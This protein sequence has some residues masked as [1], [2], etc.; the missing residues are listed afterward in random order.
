MPS[1]TENTFSCNVDTVFYHSKE[2]AKKY[3]GAIVNRL[4]SEKQLTIATARL[5]AEAITKGLCFTPA[6]L[7][8]T[9]EENFISQQSVVVDIDNEFKDIPIMTVD[10]AIRTLESNAINFA[11]IYHSFSHTPTLPKFRIVCV[12]SEPITDPEE[13][14]RLNQY[15]ISLFPQ[16]D[17]TCYN[18]DRFYYPTDK[19]LA[20]DVY[21]RTTVIKVPKDWQAKT[22]TKK[23]TKPPINTNDRKTTIKVA[24]G[25][26]FDLGNAIRTFDLLSYVE[27]PQEH[28]VNETEKT[29]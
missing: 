18:L 29:F 24:K 15:I 5:L 27:Q 11:F 17:K 23:P 26:N 28:K 25:N 9:K 2:Q 19:G 6:A 22:E 21:D 8:G 14:K 20:S 12:L 16:S 1:Q 13:A 10:E 4:K 3:I 7:N